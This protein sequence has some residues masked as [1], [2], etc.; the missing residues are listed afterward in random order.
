MSGTTLPAVLLL[1]P[2]NDEEEKVRQ[3]RLGVDIA[4]R[5]PHQASLADETGRF[6]WSGRRFRTRVDELDALWSS[7]PEPRSPS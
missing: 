3:L 4:C 1:G 5:T 2:D 7:L 6:L